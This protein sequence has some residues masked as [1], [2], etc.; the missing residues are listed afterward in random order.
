MGQETKRKVRQQQ[1]YD[2]VAEL[3]HIVDKDERAFIYV[4]ITHYSPIVI[5]FYNNDTSAKKAKKFAEYILPLD[6]V[7]KLEV[8]FTVKDKF[9]CVGT[10]SQQQECVKNKGK[11]I[12]KKYVNA[13][14]VTTEVNE[15]IDT[16]SA[17]G[18]RKQAYADKRNH[19]M[20]PDEVER[21]QA[22][23]NAMQK[24]MQEQAEE[25]DKLLTKQSSVLEKQ[26]SELESLKKKLDNAEKIRS[27]S[28]LKR[29]ITSLTEERDQLLTEN[30]KLASKE[31]A[32]SKKAKKEYDKRRRAHSPGHIGII[33]K[34]E[35]MKLGLCRES[36]LS[37][38]WHNQF[39]DASRSLLNFESFD[40]CLGYIRVLFPHLREEIATL[41]RMGAQLYVTRKTLSPLEQCIL[42]R[43][44]PKI[45]IYDKQI[46][47]IYG[48]SESRVAKIKKEWM[49][50]WGYAG[51]MLTD[52]ELYEDYVQKERPDAYY[53]NDLPDMGTQ[54]DGKD[55]LC[56]SFR[57]SSALNRAQHSS[58]LKAAALRCITW[59]SLCGLVWAFTPLVLARLTENLLVQ[60]YGEFKDDNKYV[61]IARS[62]WEVSSDNSDN[63]LDNDEEDRSD[64]D[65]NDNNNYSEEDEDEDEDED[66]ERMILSYE[67]GDLT[68]D[69]DDEDDEEDDDE[70]IKECYNDMDD[71]SLSSCSSDGND[72]ETQQK[73]ECIDLEKEL[74][75]FDDELLGKSDDKK[76]VSKDL[77]RE[78]EIKAMAQ[79]VLN[80]GPD[81]NGKTKLEQL[82][83]LQELHEE[84][85]SGRLQKCLLSMYLKLTVEYRI[86]VITL[87]KMY[88]DGKLKD[89]PKIPRRLA[90]LPG[91]FKVLAD[92]GFDGDNLSYPH[93]NHVVTPEF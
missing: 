93:F 5:K 41:K 36:L 81:R 54:C 40:E 13:P 24:Q 37:R 20:A 92:R 91:L 47:F 53:D 62:D 38:D 27:T 31:E 2:R 49:P 67:V 71:M 79:E 82:E 63:T 76:L 83:M 43:L 39:S 57:R 70:R 3:L 86:E 25:K 80:S 28:P 15:V 85:E 16:S 73:D 35:L 58:K 90:K 21:L 26:S 68:D 6:L 50:Q 44:S 7:K 30:K 51:K 74:A 52:L 59:S 29:T 4:A 34:D 14:F 69:E 22:K 45:G 66:D 42:C 19:S 46:G 88:R 18:N 32:S 77:L 87:L 11:C 65:G 55:F 60:W 48:I 61:P 12:C 10:S 89:P 64:N 17:R 75:K 33:P 78:D 84:Y 23:N 1:I 56:Q 9:D 8:K 72:D